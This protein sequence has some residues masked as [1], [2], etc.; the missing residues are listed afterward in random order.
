MLFTDQALARRLEAVE[1]YNALKAVEALALH[2]P[3]SNAVAEPIAGGYAVF[4]G[5]GSPLT[6]A[7]GLGMDG[8]LSVADV[9]QMERFFESRGAQ[10]QIECCPLGDPTLAALSRERGYRITEWDNVYFLPL[11]D[12]QLRPVS[13]PPCA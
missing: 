9:E 6:Q 11:K 3:E 4:C 2:H 5:V 13:A 1:S 10:V 7:Q 8:P 12:Y